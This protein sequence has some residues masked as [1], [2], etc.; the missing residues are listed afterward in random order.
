MARRCP[1]DARCGT[2]FLRKDHRGLVWPY[3][4]NSNYAGYSAKAWYLWSNPNT[5]PAPFIMALLNGKQ[6]PTV[7]T[8]DTDFNTLGTQWRGFSDFAFAQCDHEGPVM[9]TGTG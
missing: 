3:P 4:S 8:A 5:G 2:R 9:S 1:V 6:S 7:E